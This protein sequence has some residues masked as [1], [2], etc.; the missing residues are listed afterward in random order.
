VTVSGGVTRVQVREGRVTLESGKT[1]HEVSAG[2]RLEIDGAHAQLVG[3]QVSH[4]AGWEWAA[5]IAPG[6]DVE[7]RPLAEFLAWI[8]R[9]H[10][11]Q[12]HYADGTHQSRAQ[13]VRLH[14]SL[15]GLEANAMIERVSLI[16]GIP[17]ALRDGTLTVGSAP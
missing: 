16:T 9:E 11:W 4:G 17:L 7:N 2:E 5:T 12:L 10:G 6:L 3:A 8:A 13:S 15:E 1:A 14:G